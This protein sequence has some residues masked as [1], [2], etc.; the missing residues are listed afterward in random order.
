MNQQVSM[1][2]FLHS[3]LVVQEMNDFTVTEARDALLAKHSEFTDE[4]E[5]RKII[6]RQLTRAIE[7]GFIIR[8]DCFKSGNKR[9]IY[10]KTEKYFNLEFIPSLHRTKKRTTTIKPS[11]QAATVKVDYITELK[12]E[13]TTYEI[14]LDTILE[15]AKEYKRLSIRFPE[16]QKTLKLHQSKAKQKSIKLLGKI[17]AL[18]NLMGYTI[19]EMGSC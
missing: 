15:E 2:V 4:V 9:I 14:D 18:Q 6:Y 16:L 3:I 13:L 19:T 11:V 1:N 10:S 8:A 12:K 7:K 17:H 5:C